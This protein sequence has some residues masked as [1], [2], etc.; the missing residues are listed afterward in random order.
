MRARSL[1]TL[2]VALAIALTAGAASAQTIDEQKDFEKGRYA[3]RTKDFVD[4]DLKF[5]KMLDPSTGTLHDKV[6]VN[7]ARMYWGAALIAI[8]HKPEALEQF[9]KILTVDPSFDPDPTVFPA[10]V[11]DAFIDTRA[12]YQKRALEN[13]EEEARRERK[14]KEDEEAAKRAQVARLKQLEMLVTEENV[15]DRH[16]RWVALLP[17]GVGQFQNGNKG[18]GW[19]FLGAES[20]LAGGTLAVAIDYYV[21]LHYVHE[22]YPPYTNKLIAQQY[23]DRA[24]EA[25]IADQIIFGVLAATAVGGILEAEASYV[26]QFSSVKPR[27]LPPLPGTSPDTKSTSQLPLL[28]WTFGAA[29][30]FGAEGKGL[31]GGMIGI[32]GRF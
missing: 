20:I 21:Q 23:N 12:G 3:Y 6:L 31:T 14:R 22:L 11:G 29:P 25:L 16:S 10:E 32:R 26:P 19:F 17:G 1:W 28:Q 27:P 7:Q 8:G 5:R 18:L 13:K 4:A 9:D 2:A 30:L 24:D 15:I